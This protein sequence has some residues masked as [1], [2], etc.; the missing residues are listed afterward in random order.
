V[1][2]WGKVE[3]CAGGVEHRREDKEVEGVGY[4]Y[5]YHLGVRRYVRFGGFV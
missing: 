3:E 5:I 1:G 2:E 4:M